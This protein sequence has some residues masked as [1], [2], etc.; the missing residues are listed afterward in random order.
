MQLYVRFN[1]SRDERWIEPS[2]NH[3]RLSICAPVAIQVLTSCAASV[4]LA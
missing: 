4:V 1:T 3:V 2:S